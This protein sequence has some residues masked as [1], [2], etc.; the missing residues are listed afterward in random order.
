V[1]EPHRDGAVFRIKLTPTTSKNA[2]GAI[3]ADADGNPLLRASTAA[4]PKGG[5]TKAALLKLFARK[6]GLPKT[7][8][9]LIA[10]D[11]SWHKTILVEGSPDE[12]I[13]A[14]DV[15]MRKMGLTG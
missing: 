11:K 4:A 7:S 9:R 14:L 8:I 15:R 12:L 2:L 6:L 1:S 3:Q 13:N 5:K 10:G